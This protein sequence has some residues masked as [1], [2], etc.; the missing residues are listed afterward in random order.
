[1]HDVVTTC[2]DILGLLLLA[3]GTAALLWPLLSLGCLLVAGVIVLLGTR[4]A[5]GSAHALVKR[6]R[7]ART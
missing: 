4:V 6:A 3:A 5:D 1:V 7:R 2:L